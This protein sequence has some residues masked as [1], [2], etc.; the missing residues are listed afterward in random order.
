MKTMTVARLSGAQLF[1]ALKA[2]IDKLLAEK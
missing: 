1:A 2:A